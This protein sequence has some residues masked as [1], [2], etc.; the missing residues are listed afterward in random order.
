MASGNDQMMEMFLFEMSTLIEQLDEVLL[1]SEKSQELTED[2]VSEIF[3][4]MHTIKGSSAMMELDLI[5]TVT[6]KLEDSFFLI[7]EH[8]I[9]QS[10]FTELFDLMLDATDFE[11]PTGGDSS[12]GELAEKRGSHQPGRCLLQHIKG[13]GDPRHSRCPGFS[14]GGRAGDFEAFCPTCAGRH[15]WSH[16]L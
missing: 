11:K 6:H 8:G 7:R 1:S 15:R 4:I 16:A 2:A 5:S 9:D 14:C 12:G 13:R 10:H 3:R